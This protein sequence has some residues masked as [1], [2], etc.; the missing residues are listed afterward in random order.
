MITKEQIKK[1]KMQVLQDLQPLHEEYAIITE[2]YNAKCTKI[3]QPF[4]DLIEQYYDEQLL[5]KNKNSIR[6]G[7]Q[8]KLG[9]K[10]YKVINRGMQFVFGEILFN[11]RVMIQCIEKPIIKLKHVHPRDLIKYEILK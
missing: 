9:K 5:D 4:L 10:T 1:S 7:Y 8:L 6:V 2:E 11:P 3:E